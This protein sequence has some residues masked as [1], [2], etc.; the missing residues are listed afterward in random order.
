MDL[1]F[2]VLLLIIMDFPKGRRWVTEAPLRGSPAKVLSLGPAD[3]IDIP[4]PRG[5]VR[6]STIEH[7]LGPTACQH[8][9]T[10]H[11]PDFLCLL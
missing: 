4:D 2:I 10:S 3:A 11:Q 1:C 9:N 6:V 5:L 8:L 7:I